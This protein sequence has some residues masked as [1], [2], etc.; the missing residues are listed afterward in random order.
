MSKHKFQTIVKAKV[1]SAALDYLNKLK[2]KQSKMDGFIYKKLALQ[3][4]L[5]SP[6]FNNESRNLLLMEYEM[7]SE[8]STE[9]L[10]V[11]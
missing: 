2:Q 4:Y 7:T 1:R 9:T 8:G 5:S 10:C 3:P 11:H 6:L